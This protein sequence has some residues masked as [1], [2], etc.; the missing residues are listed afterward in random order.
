MLW[1]YLD[2]GPELEMT[3][4]TFSACMFGSPYQKHTRL[5]CWNWTPVSIENQRC[6]L[7]GGVFSCGRTSAAPHSTLEFG[8]LSTADAA[9]YVPGL[10]QRVGVGCSGALPVHA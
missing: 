8:G 10:L 3:D 6:S 2:F 9:A 5:R 4:V 7:V 1:A